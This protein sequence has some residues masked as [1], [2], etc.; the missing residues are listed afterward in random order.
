MYKR[1][2]LRR[3][4]LICQKIAKKYNGKAEYPGWWRINPTDTG[5]RLGKRSVQCFVPLAQYLQEV[6]QSTPAPVTEPTPA[7]SPAA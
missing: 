5:W 3:S 7:P 1:Q 6:A 4:A 2:V